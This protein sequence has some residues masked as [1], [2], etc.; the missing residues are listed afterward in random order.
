MIQ[1][2][3]GALGPE[4][5][6]SHLLSFNWLEGVPNHVRLHL[7]LGFRVWRSHV[8]DLRVVL[9][10]VFD[11]L[12]HVFFVT[13]RLCLLS[14]TFE[15]LEPDKIKIFLWLRISSYQVVKKL[16]WDF[17]TLKCHLLHFDLHLFLVLVQLTLSLCLIEM[18]LSLLNSKLGLDILIVHAVE[19][20]GHSSI[21]HRRVRAVLNVC[22]Q[23]FSRQI[24][25]LFLPEGGPDW[26]HLSL[27]AVRAFRAR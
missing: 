7:V 14:E 9:H 4:A 25:Q 8:E 3:V 27:G 19:S 24:L 16:L 15:A 20:E 23:K 2:S 12:H 11:I 26:L 5:F 21:D 10:Q 18:L 17:L 1:H 13:L 22:I 6:P